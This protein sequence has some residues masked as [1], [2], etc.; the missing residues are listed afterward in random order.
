MNK[1]FI[2]KIFILST[3]II[4]HCI[5]AESTKLVELKAI[6]KDQPITI[7][8]AKKIITM[9]PSIPEATAVAVANGKIVAIGSIDSLKSWRAHHPATIDQRFKDKVIMPGFID[10]HVHPSLPAVLTQFPFLAPDDWTLPTGVFPGAKT[11]K[12]YQQKLK[13]LVAKHKDKTIPFVAWGYHQLWHGKYNKQKL[14]KLFPNTPV[15]IWH[16]SFHELFANDQALK[17]I[18]MTEE[19]TKGKAGVNWQD[20]HFWEDGLLVILPKMKFV[21]YPERYQKG[22]IN[23]TKMMQ[24]AGVTTARDMGTGIFGNPVSETALIRKVME[25]NQVPARIILTPIITDFLARKVSIPNALK[26]INQW[27][28]N[29]SHRVIFDN[30]FKF[31]IDGAI[32]SGLSQFDYPGYID[33]HKGQWL[34]PLETTYQWAKAFWKAGYQLHAHANGDGGAKAWIAIIRKLQNEHPRIDHRA[35]LEHFAYATTDE[36]RAMKDLGIVISANPYYQ[37]ILSDIYAAN[38]LGNDRARNMV[39]LG[40]AVKY[41][42]PI[43]LHSDCPMAPLSPLTLAWTAVNRVT[44][45]GIRNNPHEKI[46]VTEALKAITIDA[47]WMLRLEDKIGSIRAGKNADFAILEQD[48]YQVST[49]EIKDI[50][51]WGVMFEG[52]IYPNMAATKPKPRGNKR[53]K[54]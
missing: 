25:D 2:Q 53:K 12:D 11:P 18:G 3:L 21:F 5:F 35:T 13:T 9:E 31:M 54:D 39:P 41:H 38:W 32:Y 17:M 49:A 30:D 23:F 48:P 37:Y 16:R 22:M 45:N 19:N 36:I 44:I 1:S 15:I 4:S 40:S 27:K 28:S 33:G 20:G 34:A 46:S 47:A 51:I 50:P 6:G 24:S 7:Y 43:S 42:I 14:N 8:T 10:P 52:Q 29:N 26:E